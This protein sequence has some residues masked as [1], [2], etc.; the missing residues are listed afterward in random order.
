VFGP[1]FTNSGFHQQVTNIPPGTYYFVAYAH[2]T[3]PEPIAALVAKR[4]PGADPA[5]VV[6][7]GHDAL[8]TVLEGFLAVGFSKLVPVPFGTAIDDWER[9]LAALADATL[10]LQT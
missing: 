7:V 1:S 5:E 4:L 3:I 2:D 8:R 10:D 9:E 6:P